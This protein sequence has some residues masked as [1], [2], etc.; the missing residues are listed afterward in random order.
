MR[1]ISDR[2]LCCF[3][4]DLRCGLDFYKQN[5]PK[6]DMI[7]MNID[8]FFWHLDRINPDI[9]AN[10]QELLETLSPF[11][12]MIISQDNLSR[13]MNAFETDNTK[14]VLDLEYDYLN[15]SKLRFI[16]SIILADSFEDWE[17]IKSICR[18]IRNYKSQTFN[19]TFV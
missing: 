16:N 14:E 1:I 19:H 6:D 5:A 2:S 3:L 13:L 7:F 18:T 11:I 4:E 12:P 9:S 8:G 10:T 15:K 17:R